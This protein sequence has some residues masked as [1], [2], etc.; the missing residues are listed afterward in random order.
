MMIMSMPS[1]EKTAVV[2]VPDAYE[3][4]RWFVLPQEVSDNSE[5]KRS[6][7]G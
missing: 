5:P 4:I 1:P 7:A 2:D 3:D 6:L